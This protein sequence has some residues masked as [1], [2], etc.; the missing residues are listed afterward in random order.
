M[1][2]LLCSLFAD[3][4]AVLVAFARVAAKG[5]DAAEL[6][7]RRLFQSVGPLERYTRVVRAALRIGSAAKRE[8][9]AKCQNAKRPRRAEP[10]SPFRAGNGIRTHDFNL[11]NP[12]RA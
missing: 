3:E 12:S 5:L 9:T 6:Q 11:G 10:P 1:V 4:L 7:R 2:L 8:Q